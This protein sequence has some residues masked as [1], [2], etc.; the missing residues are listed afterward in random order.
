MKRSLLS[1]SLLYF[2]LFGSNASAQSRTYDGP[3]KMNTWSIS[4]YGGITKFFGDIKQYD[5]KLGEKENLTGGWGISINKQISPLFG[6]HIAGVQGSLA[7]SKRGVTGTRP[8]GATELNIY[9]VYFKSPSFLQATLNGNLNLS[10]L[11]FGPNKLRNW[12]IDT[13]IGAGLM[14][15]HTDLYDMVSGNLLVKSDAGIGSGSWVRND[16]VYNREWVVPVGLSV[17]YQ[18]SSRFD[19]GVDFSYNRVNTDKLDLTVGDKTDYKTQHGIW[20]VTQGESKKDGWGSVMI[21]VTYKLGKHA[22]KAKGGDYT[23][24]TG[25]YHLRWTSPESLIP[26]PYN[27]TLKDADS[28]AR[29]NMP[30]GVDAKLYTDTDGDGVAD[31]FDKEPNTP[32]GSIVSGGGVALNVAQLLA[33][34][35]QKNTNLNE[36][37]SLFSSILFETDQSTIQ[38][39]SK[40]TLSEVIELLNMRPNCRVVLVGHADSRASDP[41]NVALS[42]RRVD[43]TKRFL[44]RAGLKEPSRILVEYYGALRPVAENVTPQGQQANRRVEI[45]ILPQ[46]ILHSDYPAGFRK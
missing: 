43:A 15:Y 45:R 41:Y 29:Y 27:P 11:F 36:C 18:L 6:L 22:I 14:Y 33:Q 44:V 19:L 25:R 4:G 39:E 2:S 10:R 21:A 34:S 23:A 37:A 46:N 17:Q 38:E 24:Q 16:L 32:P 20:G 12:K 28:I 31:L 5:F 8:A 40:R 26:I 13:H 35:V 7:G 42:K 1:L 9:D 3:D 30:G